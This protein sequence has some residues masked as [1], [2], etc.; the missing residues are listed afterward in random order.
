M[1]FF[2]AVFLKLNAHYSIDRSC[3]HTVLSYHIFDDTDAKWPEAQ[4]TISAALSTFL[5]Y[6]K[7]AEAADHQSTVNE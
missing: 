7:V 6:N 2:G 5:N 1:P 4:P 3:S